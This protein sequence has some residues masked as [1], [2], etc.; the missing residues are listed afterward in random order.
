MP[1][2]T[3]DLSSL[4]WLNHKESS[5]LSQGL[6]PLVFLSVSTPNLTV[7]VYPFPCGIKWQEPFVVRW[8]HVPRGKW[9]LDASHMQEGEM[10]GIIVPQSNTICQAILWFRF[11]RLYVPTRL[12]GQP[13]SARRAPY[14]VFQMRAISKYPFPVPA[15]LSP[16][17]TPACHSRPS[18]YSIQKRGL[19]SFQPWIHPDYTMPKLVSGFV[20]W[21]ESFLHVLSIWISPAVQHL[22]IAS[23]TAFKCSQLSIWIFSTAHL[24][25]PS[26]AAYKYAQLCSISILATAYLDI[27]GCV[28]GYFQQ[29][30]WIFPAV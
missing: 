22:D 10:G 30:I 27:P 28:F 20:S 26:C 29:P 23:C 18:V 14:R 1:L 8:P 15:S 7:T 21:L 6:S 2:E 4:H 13:L 16:L 19:Y 17:W 5:T 25:I 24:D 12:Q 11:H 3:V 9:G